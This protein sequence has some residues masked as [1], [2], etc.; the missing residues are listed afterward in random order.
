MSKTSCSGC[1]RSEMMNVRLRIVPIALVG[2]V[3]Q[4]CREAAAEAD[5]DDDR[6]LEAAARV[7]ARRASRS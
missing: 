1:G 4:A 5:A 2:G 6:V 7:I 3:C